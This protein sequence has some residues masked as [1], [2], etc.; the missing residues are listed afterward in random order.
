M[1]ELQ[2]DRAKTKILAYLVFA[3]ET[4]TFRHPVARNVHKKKR[5]RGLPGSSGDQSGGVEEHGELTGQRI[6]ENL[7]SISALIETLAN[8]NRPHATVNI[9][10]DFFVGLLD[11]GAN[12]TVVGKSI[13]PYLEKWGIEKKGT[14]FICAHR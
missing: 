5:I 4:K 8:D 3:A 10:G 13:E 11:S 7:P 9:F 2:K 6:S 12:V 14:E 1:L